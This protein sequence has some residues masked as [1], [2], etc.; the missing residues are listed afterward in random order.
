M[1]KLILAALLAPAPALADYDNLTCAMALQA[2]DMARDT[3]GSCPTGSE[4]T[5]HIYGEGENWYLKTANIGPGGGERLLELKNHLTEPLRAYVIFDHEGL[6]GA[7]SHTPDGAAKL[8]LASF[9]ES[10]LHEE[11]WTGTCQSPG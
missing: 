7:F 11:Y 8:T 2:C 5:A 10:Y 4:G 3:D 9:Q 6:D 1:R